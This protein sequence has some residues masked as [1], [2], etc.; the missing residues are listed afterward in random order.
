M[1]WLRWLRWLQPPYRRDS[2]ASQRARPVALALVLLGTLAGM[3]LLGRWALH[4]AADVDLSL[5]LPQM[6]DALS[7]LRLNLPQFV[8]VYLPTS[9]E[10]LKEVMVNALK[11]H[12]ERLSSAGIEG[13]AGTLHVLWGV[14]IGAVLSL[15][16]FSAP[17]AYRPLSAALLQRLTRLSASFRKI[18]FAQIRISLVNT[19]LTATYL[20]LLL[21][22]S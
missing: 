4:F 7:R 14:V 19:I 1:R 6:A 16:T 21:P 2:C 20:L 11:M 18:V 17:A 9:P 8:L 15:S 10:T 12:G 5:V 22:L 13:M 3:V